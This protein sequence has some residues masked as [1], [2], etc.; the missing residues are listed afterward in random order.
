[1]VVRRGVCPYA[2]RV[3]IARRTCLA[4]R[5]CPTGYV[6][7]YRDGELVVKWNLDDRVP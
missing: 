1:V 7:A 2:M 5:R 4:A 3:A 6:H